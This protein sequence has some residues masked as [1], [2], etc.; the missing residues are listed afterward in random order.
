MRNSA[1]GTRVSEPI[2]CTN[3]RTPLRK[4]A[5]MRMVGGEPFCA[6]VEDCTGRKNELPPA[7][8]REHSEEVV[9]SISTARDRYGWRSL[10]AGSRYLGP[11]RES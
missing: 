4:F 1:D 11:P 5:E 7:P 2:V 3:C 10:P 9:V 6:N 8:A